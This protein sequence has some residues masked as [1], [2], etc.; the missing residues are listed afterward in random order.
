MVH[1]HWPV[2]LL[3]AFVSLDFVEVTARKFYG[4]KRD[5]NGPSAHVLS[6]LPHEDPKVLQAL[7]KQWDWRDVDGVDYTSEVQNQHQPGPTYCG[8]CWAFA[9]TIHLNARFNIVNGGKW[10]RTRLSVQV[11]ITCGPGMPNGCTGSDPGLALKFIHEVGLPHESCH[12]YEAKNLI[13]NSQA[14]CQDCM[15]DFRPECWGRKHFP[16]YRV[17]EYGYIRPNGNVSAADPRERQTVID[18]MVQRMKAE[19]SMR[20]PIVCQLACPDPKSGPPH[21]PWPKTGNE[22]FGQVRGYVDD[23][24]PFFNDEGKNYAPFILHDTDYVCPGGDWDKCVDHDITVIGWGV[25]NGLPYWIIQNSWG[26]WWGEHGFFRIVMGKNNLGIESACYWGVP[27]V[28][29][30]AKG[31]FYGSSMASTQVFE[32]RFKMAQ[33]MAPQQKEV[34]LYS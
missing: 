13:C 5:S 8:A 23:Y 29:E 1:Q 19:I 25:E 32:K 28:N 30:G 18:N 3:A 34:V 31:G 24:T 17:K 9:T 4:H 27:A 26:A 15:T 21:S 10:P 6:A 22:T 11:L 20:G 33:E 14:V 7:P 2:A 12:E 16:I